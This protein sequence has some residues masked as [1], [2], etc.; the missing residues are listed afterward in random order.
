MCVCV[1]V[2]VCMCASVHVCVMC[3]YVDVEGECVGVW[4]VHVYLIVNIRVCVIEH[5]IPTN[6]SYSDYTEYR[7]QYTVCTYR[8]CIALCVQLLV[9]NGG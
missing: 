2:C 9:C 1:C 6:I 3:G 8:Y 5:V 7:V 4:C